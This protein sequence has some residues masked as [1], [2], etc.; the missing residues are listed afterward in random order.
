MGVTCAEAVILLLLHCEVIQ[1][2]QIE[3]YPCCLP[4]FFV[5]VRG[6]DK[7]THKV[8]VDGLRIAVEKRFQYLSSIFAAAHEGGYSSHICG[9]FFQ[10]SIIAHHGEPR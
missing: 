8:A 7:E 9:F 10:I 2:G 6:A 3:P 5:V 1:V 4:L